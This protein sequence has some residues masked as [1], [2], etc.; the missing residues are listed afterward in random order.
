MPH[1]NGFN[2]EGGGL[3]M[4]VTDVNHAKRW[5]CGGSESDKSQERTDLLSAG[6]GLIYRAGKL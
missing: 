4:F 2:W 3:Q 6:T 1:I 5:D